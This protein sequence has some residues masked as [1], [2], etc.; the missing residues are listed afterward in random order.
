MDQTC[1]DKYGENNSE[2][3]AIVDKTNRILSYFRNCRNFDEAYE[4]EEKKTILSFA[5]KKKTNLGK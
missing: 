3:K 1:Y 5:F 2:L 4:P